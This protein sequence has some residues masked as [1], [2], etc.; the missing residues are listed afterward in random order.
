MASL[1]SRARARLND[2]VVYEPGQKVPPCRVAER[3]PRR[4]TRLACSIAF[5]LRHLA[6]ERDRLLDWLLIFR[7]QAAANLTA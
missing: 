2:Q 3:R 1:S 4:G 7:C 5:H 6:D